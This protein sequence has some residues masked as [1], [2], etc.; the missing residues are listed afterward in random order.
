[1]LALTHFVLGLAVAHLMLLLFFL[2]ADWKHAWRSLRTL[3]LPAA[4]LV[5]AFSALYY[6]EHYWYR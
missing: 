4:F 2:T 1:M 5:V 3:G 6:L